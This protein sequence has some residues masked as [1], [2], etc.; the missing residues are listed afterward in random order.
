ML[1]KYLCLGLFAAFV[2]TN[3]QNCTPQAAGN[4]IGDNGCVS[5]TYQNQTVSY[6]TVRAADCYEWLQQ[7]L[8]SSNVATSIADE[9][10]RGDYFQYGRWDDGHQLKTSQTTDVYP[11]PN[12]PVG[13]GNGTPQFY[14]GGGT[15][16]NSDYKGWFANPDQNDTWSAKNLSEVTEHNG[17]DPCKAIG[18][19]WEMPSEADWDVVMQ[20]ENIFPRPVGATNGGIVR[21]FESNLKIA[22]AGSRKD[23]GWAFEG[24]RAYIWTKS[25]STNPNFY[26]FVYLGAA[27][28]STTGFGGDAKS[29]GYSIR[30]VNKS[31]NTLAVNDFGKTDFSFGPNPADKFIKINTEDALKSVEVL[32]TTGQKISETKE[33]TV[34]VS[35]LT[36]GNYFIKIT[37]E[38]GK[39]TTKKFIKK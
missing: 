24:T 14:I 26:R 3:A 17:I 8:G 20:K 9:G 4:N 1:N 2:N 10:A 32:S 7:N 5:L 38:N 15:P 35:G 36:K 30:C 39:T 6:K 13:L 27:A 37:F 16:W 33:N 25:A 22:G 11:T 21:G 12:N 29:F 23:L 19:N 31:N 18:D 34:D 28:S